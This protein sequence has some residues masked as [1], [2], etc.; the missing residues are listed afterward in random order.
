MIIYCS[1]YFIVCKLQHY[2]STEKLGTNLFY[3]STNLHTATI[4]T[5]NK[6]VHLYR[7]RFSALLSMYPLQSKIRNG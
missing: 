4:H 1:V 7:I 5:T 6:P 2:T 3:K